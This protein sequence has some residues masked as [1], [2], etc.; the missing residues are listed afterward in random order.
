MGK[1][2]DSTIL[3]QWTGTNEK[4]VDPVAS[5]ETPWAKARGFAEAGK[6]HFIGSVIIYL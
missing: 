4:S 1:Y 3:L 6:N 5:R 2:L